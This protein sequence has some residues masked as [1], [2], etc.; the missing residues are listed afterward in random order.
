MIQFFI[1][2]NIVVRNKQI[3]KL[4]KTFSDSN[5]QIFYLNGDSNETSLLEYCGGQTLFNESV[6]VVTHSFLEDE[7]RE[8]F[9]IQEVEK[10]HLSETHFVFVERDI[11]SST[12]TFLTK[13]KINI[14]KYFS[15]TKKPIQSFNPF[16][17]G[18]ALLARDKK[19]LW[20]LY[21]KAQRANI[22]PE[23][24]FHTLNW[25][26]KSL[27]IVSESSD[28]IKLGMKPFVI[29]KTKRGLSKFS[30]KEIV[31]LRERFTEAFHMWRRGE[32]VGVLLEKIILSI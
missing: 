23:D 5:A 3:Q 20:V 18:D 11:K 9:F 4:I 21:E 7:N 13:N 10:L 1:G 28:P 24:I 32:D 26:M 29:Q 6:C 19:L 17:L 14:E 16:S 15:D 31:E 8:N 22:S 25:Q 30:S 12:K 27:H 2:D